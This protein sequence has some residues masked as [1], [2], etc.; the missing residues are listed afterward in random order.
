MTGISWGYQRCSF[1]LAWGFIYSTDSGRHI[2]KINVSTGVIA[3]YKQH[4][5]VVRVAGI[6]SR[7]VGRGIKAVHPVGK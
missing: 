7:I 1:I 3:V 6:Y 5:R 2:E 4:I